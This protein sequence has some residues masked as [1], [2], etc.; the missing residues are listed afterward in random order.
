MT[1]T[2][3]WLVIGGGLTGAALAYELQKTGLAV[4]VVEPQPLSPLPPDLTTA[5]STS[6]G[7]IPYWVAQNPIMAGLARQSWRRYAELA[8][9]LVSDTLTDLELRTIDLLLTVGEAAPIP[10]LFAHDPADDS[11]TTAGNTSGS[12]SGIKLPWLSRAEVIE[13][14]PALAQAQPAVLGGA[15]LAK[16]GHIHPIKL[17]QGYLQSFQR[18]GGTIITAR[19]TALKRDGCRVVGVETDRGD[20][21]G[22]DLGICG[23]GWSRRLL[24]E[25]GMP[26]LGSGIYFTHAEVLELSPLALSSASV[27][28]PKA[29]ILPAV[30]D[31]F[32]IESAATAADQTDHWQAKNHEFLPPSLDIGAIPFRD[33][34]LRF[35]QVSRVHSNPDLVIDPH[36]SEMILREGLQALLPQLSQLPAHWYHSIVA[37]SQDSL[38]LVGAFPEPSN[39]HLFTGFTTP[40]AYVPGLATLFATHVSAP[41][42]STQE[43]MQ[44][45]NPSRFGN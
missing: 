19:V 12:T 13:L 23:G 4:A 35:G 27:L 41:T 42:A 22:M 7:G 11:P 24:Q 44:A 3:D 45:L 34:R 9:E 28:S 6:Y 17:V 10:E 2:Y 30:T 39:V 25:S 38:P 20:F 21:Y 43:T 15:L 40:F 32:A 31:R 29:M 26:S 18:L 8:T 5:T 36:Q 37:F 1:N 14:E 16:H 33:G